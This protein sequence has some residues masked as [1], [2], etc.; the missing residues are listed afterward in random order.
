MSNDRD[1]YNK[2]YQEF[3]L[4]MRYAEDLISLL[5]GH[6]PNG[7]FELYAERIFCK[8]VVSRYIFSEFAT[9]TGDAL[10]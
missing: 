2:S 5:V 8:A 1:K 3:S 7:E 10:K 6:T 4:L 9:S